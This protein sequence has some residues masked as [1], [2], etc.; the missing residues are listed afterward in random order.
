[1]FRILLLLVPV[2]MALGADDPWA[3]VSELKRGTQVW[4]YKTGAKQALAGTLDETR[5]QSLVVILKNQQVAIPKDE[6]DRVAIRPTKTRV[7]A[8][9]RTKT[10]DPTAKERDLDPEQGPGKPTQT[11]AGGIRLHP[12]SALQTIYQRQA[13]TPKK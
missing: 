5:E 6:I 4:V 3:K 11:T 8:E 1:M 12:G 9:S 7:T 10:S 2:F 13:E